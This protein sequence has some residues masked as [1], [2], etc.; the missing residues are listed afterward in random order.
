VG[1]VLVGHL[2][3]ITQYL[4]MS[5]TRIGDQKRFSRPILGTTTELSWNNT[6]AAMAR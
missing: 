6:R 4:A 5:S 3:N 2:K 1:A